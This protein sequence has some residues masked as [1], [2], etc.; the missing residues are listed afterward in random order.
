MRVLTVLI[1]VFGAKYKNELRTKTKTG[2]SHTFTSSHCLAGSVNAQPARTRL[3]VARP[4]LGPRR[5]P[6]R[7][8]GPFRSGWF[9][10][11]IC[12]PQP[13]PACESAQEFQH[14]SDRAGVLWVANPR[15]PASSPNPRPSRARQQEAG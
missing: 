13:L 12:N 11:R 1:P 4:D 2:Q 3:G 5:V 14:H 7:V 8:F 6:S 15:S 10:A 9:G